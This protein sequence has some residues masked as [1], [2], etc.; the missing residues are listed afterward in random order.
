VLKRGSY[1]IILFNLVNKFSID[2][3]TQI[4]YPLYITCFKA[5][6]LQ[7]HANFYVNFE[8]VFECVIS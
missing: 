4:Q 5:A 7:I 3:P 8:N 2:L 6:R 1:N